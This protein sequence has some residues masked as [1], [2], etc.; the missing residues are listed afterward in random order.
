VK[1]KGATTVSIAGVSIAGDPLSRDGED[2]ALAPALVIAWS[3]EEPHRVGEVACFA[4]R[5]RPQVLGRGDEDDDEAGPSGE[6]PRDRARF[7]RQRPG[8]NVDAG[9]LEGRAISRKQLHVQ[10]RPSSLEVERIGRCPMLVNGKTVDKGAVKPGDTVELKS[11]LLLLCVLRARV[12]PESRYLAPSA[13]GPFGEADGAGV[14][15]ESPVAWQL[16]DRIAFASKASTH[17]LLRGASGTGKELAARAIHHLG[18]RAGRP[19][20]SRNAATFPSGLIDAELFGNV[21][22]Y[23]NPGMP[24][25]PGLVGQ[26]DGGT[27]FL[28]EI[29]ELPQDM[30]AHLLRVLDADG[31]YQR[32]GE[33]TMRRADIRLVGATNRD[34]ASLK[35]DLLARLTVRVELPPLGER[36]EDIPL[37]VRHLLLRAANK[38]PEIA[39]RFVN[40]G[41]T[42]R[43]EVRVA[44][45]LVAAL[46]RRDYET[47]VRELDAILWRAM[48]ASTRDVVGLPEDMRGEPAEDEGAGAR[49]EEDPTAEQV[50]GALEQAKGNVT[51]AARSLGLSSRYALYRL[52]KRHGIEGGTNE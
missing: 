30:Q 6:G 52:M 29:A 41:P 8:D 12:M 22:N 14:L 18:K 17:V 47:N 39:G 3:A 45:A 50:R 19:L 5:G 24:E 35:H 20:V 2:Q 38:S 9:P 33:A 13:L 1:G 26:A 46:L 10:G 11:Q 21:K 32:L 23:P 34:P 27:L 36:R 40:K 42:G 28:D 7:V 4:G 15:G 49:V 51:R 16:R 25:R 43:D 44:A 48:A 31:E 37:L